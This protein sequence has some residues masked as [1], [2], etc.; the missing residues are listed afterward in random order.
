MIQNE[1]GI[2]YNNGHV[3][4]VADETQQYIDG[5]QINGKYV[6]G[7][8]VVKND[9]Y[10]VTQNVV[11]TFYISQI[12]KNVMEFK[13]PIPIQS[14]AFEYRVSEEPKKFTYTLMINL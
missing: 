12:E 13:L 3:R 7:E 5:V 6:L 11:D 1:L 9:W 4:I 2:T 8:Y 14:L 10:I